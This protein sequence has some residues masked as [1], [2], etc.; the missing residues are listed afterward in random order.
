MTCVQVLGLVAAC[1]LITWQHGLSLRPLSQSPPTVDDIIT[2]VQVLGL[3][4]ACQLITWHHGLSLRRLLTLL[5]SVRHRRHSTMVIWHRH[6]VTVSINWCQYQ[7]VSV[8]C[9]RSVD[10]QLNIELHYN[11]VVCVVRICSPDT[12]R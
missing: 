11:T 2:C 9:M 5:H 8:I 10:K 7:F 4:A 12:K 1:R 3:A 6:Q